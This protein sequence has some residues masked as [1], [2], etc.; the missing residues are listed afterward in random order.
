MPVIEKYGRL[1]ERF[2]LTSE[3][4]ERTEALQ[5][6]WAPLAGENHVLEVMS[7]R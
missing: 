3:Q 6:A 5:E 1:T 7:G 4:Q 2:G